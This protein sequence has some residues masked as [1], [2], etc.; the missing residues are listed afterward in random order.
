MCME[1][2]LTGTGKG[3]E[4]GGLGFNGSIGGSSMII[5]G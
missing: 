3:G 2:C 4:G 1:E 5:G